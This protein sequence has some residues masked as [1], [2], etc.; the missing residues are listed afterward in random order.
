M[1]TFVFIVMC[2]YGCFR[3][4]L[5]TIQVRNVEDIDQRLREISDSLSSIKLRMKHEKD[6]PMRK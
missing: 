3:A 4:Y 2:I 1:Y 5:D 6:E